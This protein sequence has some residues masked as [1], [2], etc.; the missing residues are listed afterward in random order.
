MKTVWVVEDNEK[1]RGN[2]LLQLREAG[3]ST[4]GMTTAEHAWVRLQ[5]QE[6]PL[7][8]L[9]LLDVRLSGMS[10]VELVRRLS[11]RKE[12]PPTIV[13][14][15][16]ASITETVDALRLGVHDFIEKPFSRERL[17]QSVRNCLEYA[18]LKKQVRAL[19]LRAR[20]ETEFLGDS[21]PIHE[22]QALVQKVA[23]TEGRVLIRGESGTG[24]ELV[25]NL[26]HRFSLR[27]EKP[28]VK[29]NCAALPVHLVEDEI[30]GHIRGAFTDARSPKAGLFEE[31]DGG[32]LFLDEIGDMDLSLQGK[33]LRVL[34][35]GRVRRLGETADRKVDVRILT[36]T[37]RNLEEMVG[38][39]EFRED[40][41]FR[42]SAVP[43]QV[44]PL[45]EHPED[46]PLLFS[47]FMDFFCAQ[48]RVRHKA[49]DPE[50][51][52]H[53]THYHWPGNV[54]ELKNICERLVIFG[55]D[56]ITLDQLPSPLF[57][58]SQ[59]GET[60]IV[61][62]A[63][64]ASTRPLKE[65]RALCEKEYIE[66]TLRKTNWNFS[67]AARLLAIQRTYLHQKVTTLGIERPSGSKTDEIKKP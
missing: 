66:N 32:I 14:S 4:Q 51:L 61:P 5:D 41:Y 54:R 16:E 23:P 49:V 38:N 47:H 67:A 30:F 10:G 37:H 8:D 2:L 11:E 33:L 48:H 59:R 24:K 15:G 27:R 40:L 12:M 64:M 1:I 53:L 6:H 57:A 58:S 35:D 13:I 65:F 36:A 45:R 42:L 25:A 31:A 20:S 56:P 44:P 50:V 26:I 63:Q 17:L 60:G 34:E 55:A 18:D 46:I 62:L 7:P 21:A 43:I 29:I 52:I 3:F 9:L 22:L 39:R 28:F 19:T